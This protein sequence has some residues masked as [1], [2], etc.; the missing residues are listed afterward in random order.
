MDQGPRR[1]PR[2]T[3]YHAK[4]SISWTKPQPPLPQKWKPAHE[5]YDSPPSIKRQHSDQSI[6]PEREF[7]LSH[8]DR[9]E[10]VR[11]I[12]P[13]QQALEKCIETKSRIWNIV[14]RNRKF[15][16][17]NIRNLVWN[18]LHGGFKI[19]VEYRVLRKAAT[20]LNA[21]KPKTSTTSCF[22]AP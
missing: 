8:K 20:S 11:N 5:E 22:C 7:S 1:G 10:I 18:L 16:L 2:R 15:S 13:I 3:G 4:K 9:P 21:N 19:G 17:L 6:E 14:V 12:R